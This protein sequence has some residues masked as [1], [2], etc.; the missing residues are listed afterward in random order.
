MMQNSFFLIFFVIVGNPLFKIYGN[1]R[2]FL[3]GVFYHNCFAITVW[4]VIRPSPAL[5]KVI[6]LYESLIYK[7]LKQILNCLRFGRILLFDDHYV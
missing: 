4:M 5:N 6:I 1:C 3:N 2:L 7:E